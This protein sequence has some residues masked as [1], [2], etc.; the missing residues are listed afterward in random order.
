MSDGVQIHGNLF[1]PKT[2]SSKLPLIIFVNSWVLEEHEYFAQAKK[3]AE[4]GYLVFSYSTRGWGCSGGKV[5]VIGPRDIADLETVLDW[6]EKETP[7]DV[8]NIGM[9]GIS[10]GGGMSLMAAAKVD[11]IKTV[12][13][14]SA[15][16]NLADAVYGNNTPRQ[17]WSSVL[18]STGAIIGEVDFK[19]LK[20]FKALIFNFLLIS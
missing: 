12:A 6:L 2:D 11:R 20:L 9:S 15:W 19:L 1:S 18:I 17:F 13:A 8:K 4:K 14:M 7:V 3:L 16:G 5:D 10:Y